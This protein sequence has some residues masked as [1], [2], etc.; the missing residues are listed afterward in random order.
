MKRKLMLFGVAALI[1]ST[2]W[3]AP[4]S[5]QNASDFKLKASSVESSDSQLVI[6]LSG[7]QIEDLYAYEAKLTFDPAKLELVT[8]KTDIKGFSVSPI[9]K[10][11]EI[12]FAHTKIGK[13][14]GEKGK[15]DITKLTFK[16]KQAGTSQVKWTGMKIVDHNLKNQNL[17]P[18]LATSFTKLFADISG[19]WAKKDIMD[20]VDRGIITGMNM[21]TFAPNNKVTRAQFAKLIAGGLKLE[22][23]TSNPFKD[24]KAGAWYEDAVK[25]AVAA[26]I[27]TGVSAD[28][29]NPEKAITR[30]EMAVMLVRAKAYAQG[31]K[32]ETLQ[33]GKLP[34]FSDDASISGW[35]RPSLSIAVEAKLL[36]GR[37]ASVLAPKGQT[38]RAESA[39]VLKRLL[40]S[41]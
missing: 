41:L 20:M 38:T 14:N 24:V 6:T 26:G 36:Q 25:S 21:D 5:A 16:S 23:G 22:A 1:C 15:L 4:A 9:V 40:T 32:P 30:E 13:V 33:A 29:F 17:T 37:T 12:T 11:G 19:H 2:M 3:F 10:N 8:A 27:V 35:A 18:N 31:V 28:T 39:V 34:A 7:E